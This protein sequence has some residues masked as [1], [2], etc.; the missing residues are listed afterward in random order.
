MY[1]NPKLFILPP[2][3]IRLC[4]AVALTYGSLTPKGLTTL[5]HTLKKYITPHTVHGLDLGCGDGELIWHLKGMLPGSS[6]SG[7]EIS[8]E[9]VNLQTR[10][11]DIW[12][13]DMLDESL[14]HYNVLHADNLCLSEDTAEALEEKIAHEFQG[15][16]ISYRKPVSLTFLKMSF[17]LASVEVETSWSTCVIHFYRVY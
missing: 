1:L 7:V 8:N 12:Q 5:C 2:S 10:E 6:W 14:H 11:V 4:G 9:R 17:K 16:F 13:G 15:I 3:E